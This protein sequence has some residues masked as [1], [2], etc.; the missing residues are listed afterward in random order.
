MQR[1]RTSPLP[2]SSPPKHTPTPA[3]QPRPCG[4]SALP[5]GPWN[6]VIVEIT[7]LQEAAQKYNLEPEKEFGAWFKDMEWLSENER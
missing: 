6:T 3:P 1:P 4:P 2:H 7:L 5:S